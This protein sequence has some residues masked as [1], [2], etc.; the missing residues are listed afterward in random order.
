MLSEIKGSNNCTGNN[1]FKKNSS[2]D[3]KLI[4]KVQDQ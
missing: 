3:E 1:I 4:Y 2:E